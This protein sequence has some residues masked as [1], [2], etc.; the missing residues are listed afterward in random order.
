MLL[1]LVLKIMRQPHCVATNILTSA[2]AVWCLAVAPADASETLTFTKVCE[3]FQGVS[4]AWNS[5][6]YSRPYT[7][8]TMEAIMSALAVSDCRLAELQLAAINVLQ[9][10]QLQ[11]T[12]LPEKSLMVDFPTGVDLQMI[13]IA[14]PNLTDLN[15]SGRVIQDLTPIAAFTQ[16][17]TLRLANTQLRDISALPALTQLTTLDISYN[18]IDNIAPLA[19]ITTIR[20]LNVSYNPF[21][22]VSPIG[23]ILTPLVEQ[24]WQLL[25]LSGIDID[26]ATCPDNL[27]DICGEN[28]QG[29]G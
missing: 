14:T 4:D 7:W 17:K 21:T 3:A 9:G 22:D 18:Q 8:Q 1:N 10:P 16:L 28:L 2:A 27:G 25:D 6:L 11:T 20:A 26:P 29:E 15:L 23:Q 13:E 24:E 5:E 12:F 19:D